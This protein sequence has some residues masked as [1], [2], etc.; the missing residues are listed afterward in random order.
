MYTGSSV[1]EVRGAYAARHSAWC[2][3]ERALGHTTAC[4]AAISPFGT[5]VVAVAKP[6]AWFGDSDA[7]AVPCTLDRRTAFS[8]PRFLLSVVGSFLFWCAPELSSS[9]PFRLTGGTLG[10]VAL[11][12]LV[13]LFILY[14]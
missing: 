10:F 1:P 5:T 14:R 9:T 2:G 12:S 4:R 8:M 13:L 6:R 7:A 11:S 3:L